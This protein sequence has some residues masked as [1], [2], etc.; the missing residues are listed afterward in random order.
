MHGMTRSGSS[1]DQ[2]AASF[3]KRRVATPDLAAQGRARVRPSAFGNPRS[4]FS[5]KEQRPATRKHRA[6]EPCSESP[7]PTPRSH[8]RELLTLF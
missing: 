6:I 5:C 7:P 4:E 3:G 1:A 8:L 2:L